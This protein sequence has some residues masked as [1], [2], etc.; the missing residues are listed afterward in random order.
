MDRSA[1]NSGRGRRDRRAN[2]VL[3]GLGYVGARMVTRCQ[4]LGQPLAV[5]SRQPGEGPLR[6]VLDLDAPPSHLPLDLAPGSTVFYTVP[7]PP[8]GEGDPRLEALL[9]LLDPA[10]CRLVYLGTTGVYG[11][12][13]GQLVNE[14]T[15]LRPASDRARRRQRAERALAQW[16]QARPASACVLRVPGIYGPQRLPLDLLAAGAPFIEPAQAPPGNRIHVDDLISAMLAAGQ[17]RQAHGA[18][19]VGDGS[20]MS[21]TEFA[22]ATARL[23]GMPPPPLVSLQEA[24]AV[25]SPGRWSFMRESRRLDTRRMREELGVAV[26]YAD[27][28]QGIRAS[29][30][31]MGV[32]PRR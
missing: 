15:A 22:M 16:A 12:S 1:H 17:N 19:N 8:T 21:S 5:L 29:L 4:A 32:I 30:E 18:F 25:I 31:E 6:A 13:G 20:D 11:D 26:R 23:A 2:L 10:D 27:P 28:V 3:V 14:T 7:P 24:P 9:A